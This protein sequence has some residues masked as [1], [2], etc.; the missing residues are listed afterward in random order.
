MRPAGKIQPTIPQTSSATVEG[1]LGAKET[2]AA[3]VWEQLTPT[4]QQVVFQALVQVGR[5]LMGEEGKH[6]PA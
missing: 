6:G 3:Q 2:P 5:R 1:Q 4:Q